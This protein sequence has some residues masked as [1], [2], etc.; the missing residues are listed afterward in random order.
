[1]KKFTFTE[2]IYTWVH[3]IN[4]YKRA[5][6]LKI[7]LQIQCS[8]PQNFNEFICTEIDK[9]ILKIILKNKKNKER[10]NNHDKCR[11]RK[12]RQKRTQRRRGRR[13][14]TNSEDIIILDIMIY[15]RNMGK[16]K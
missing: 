2:Y 12:R 11:V 13:R 8:L 4:Y 14:R 3:K 9:A 10:Q 5:I 15:H 6:L 1:M 16:W 7:N